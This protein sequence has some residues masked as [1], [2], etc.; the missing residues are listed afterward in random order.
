MDRIEAMRSFVQV[1][2]AGSFTQ[3]AM[4]LGRNKTTVSDHVARLEDHLGFS[5]FNRTTRSVVPTQEGLQYARKVSF[6]LEQLDNAELQLKTRTRSAQGVL[7][8]EMPSP[9]GH[10]LVV[11]QIQSF[12]AQY[13]RITLDLNCTDRHADLHRDGIDCVLRGGVLPD[14]SL[15]CRKLCDLEF[16][17][18]A[19]PA[20]LSNHG[21][22]RQPADLAHHHQIGYRNATSSVVQPIRLTRQSDVLEVDMARR[23]VV[24]D[25][26]TAMQAGLCGLG[27]LH[28][29]N[30]AM[31]QYVRAGTMVRLLPEWRGRIMPLTLL[32]PGNRFRTARVQVFMDWVQALLMR[33][34]ALHNLNQ[35]GG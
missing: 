8:V 21:I 13:P 15:I 23:L 24:S 32:S 7:K 29:S 19:S 11:P 33:S 28:A 12:L 25:V 2:E 4:L 5:L 27:I 1:V 26:V 20:Y 35:S 30:F 22:P 3:A 17:L 14:S 16:A 34:M 10:L 9:I 18:F 6:I 31:A